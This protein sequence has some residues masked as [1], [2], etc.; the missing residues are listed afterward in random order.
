MNPPQE[1]IKIG[2]WLTA[3]LELEISNA[4]KRLTH[5]EGVRHIAIM[6]DVHLSGE[7][8]IGTVVATKSQIYP[9]AVGNDIGCGM[10]TIGFDCKAQE[11]FTDTSA[12]KIFEEL[13]RLI[14]SN[15]HSRITAKM[16]LPARLQ[17]HPLSDSKLEK[18]KTRDGRVQFGTLGRG[19]H[20]LE[21]Q[22]DEDDMLWVTV[23]SGSRGVGQQ[24]VSHHLSQAQKIKSGL[25]FFEGTSIAGQAYLNDHQWACSYAEAN[26]MEMIERVKE[27]LR[28]LFN[29]NPLESTLFSCDHNHV[30]QESHFGEDFFVHRKGS[31]SARQGEPGIIPGS[32]GAPTFHTR[33]R[34]CK[35]SLCSS[36]HGAGRLMSRGEARRKITVTNLHRQMKGVWFDHRMGKW[37]VDEAPSSYKDINSVMRAQ[38]DLTRIIRKLTPLLNYKGA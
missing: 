2:E 15:R 36:S 23:H 25:L 8:C 19:N 7:V 26:R 21:F 28:Q 5:S 29:I 35:E 13:Y 22:A 33:G 17:N 10:A 37:L 16:E 12:A 30:R 11:L 34:G 24:I 3:P 32:M 4:I 20:F 9:Q 38:K 31:L 18:S 27:L 1:S 14:P 6:P